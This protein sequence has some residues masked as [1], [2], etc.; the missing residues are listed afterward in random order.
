MTLP[1][2]GVR[3]VDLT[4]VLAG[5]L[6]TMLLGDL[7]ADVVKI[8]RPGKGDDTRAWGPP[9]QEGES[10]Y[11]LG[12]NRNKRSVTLDTSRPE[13][14]DVLGRLLEGAD[15]V[16]DNFKLGTLDRW[17]FDDAWFEAHAPAAVRCSITGYGSTGP[18]GAEPGYDF[19]LQ[20]ES[21]LMAITGP[22]DGEPTKSGVALVDVCTGLMAAI[23]LLGGLED[24][25][26]TGRGRRF[27]VS[28][29]DTS[30]TMLVNVA[31]NHLMSGQDAARFGN[32]HPNIVPYRTFAAADGD[33]AVA[34]GNDAQFARL[35]ELCGHPEWAT[36]ERFATNRARVVHRVEIDGLVQ[37]AFRAQP[38]SH[39]VEAL[40]A[41]GIPVGPINS[42][43]EALTSVQSVARGLV[44][45]V[46]HPHT[47][48][49][50]VVTSPLRWGPDAAPVRIPPP[51]LGEHTDE[52]L[53]GELGLS[54]DEVAALR[55]AGVV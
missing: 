50:S 28:L 29:H 51:R 9:F 10:A 21:G 55:D 35:A 22:E 54:D 12:V 48:T 33:V 25:R 17:G 16:I 38:R 4:R 41:E 42:V 40:K 36:D 52:V 30:L 23:S 19:I 14:R 32:G 11:F 6:A 20:A 49:F 45:E 53:T 5:P 31:A 8:E 27:E 37:Q 18:R 39:W 46:T 26:R 47:G 7:G 44:T 13:G 24:R 3:V 1:L 2:D 34:V 15:L 43:R